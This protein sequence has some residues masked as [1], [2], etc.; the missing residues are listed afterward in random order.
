M[1]VSMASSWQK[2]KRR[3]R[4]SG[5]FQWSSRRWVMLVTPG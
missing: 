5:S 4:C 3:S 2:K 1:R